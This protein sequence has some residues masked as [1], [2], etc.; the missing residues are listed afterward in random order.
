[1]VAELGFDQTKWIYA[2]YLIRARL[3]LGKLHPVF[4]QYF[5]TTPRGRR[6]LRERCK[7]SAGQ[8]NINTKGLGSLSIPVPEI[9]KQHKF[10]DKIINIRNE[11]GRY[12]S[13]V[14]SLDGLF[15]S[16]Q[17]RAFRGEL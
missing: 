16:L 4:L 8:F 7:T 2:S 5:L 10:A 3:R 13:S 12:R 17:Q 11:I 15:A 1:M 9:D 14:K 6:A